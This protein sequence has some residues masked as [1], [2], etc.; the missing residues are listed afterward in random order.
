[1]TSLNTTQPQVSEEIQNSEEV[2]RIV[3]CNIK[4]TRRLS[5]EFKYN[6]KLTKHKSIPMTEGTFNV[7][8]VKS[9]SEFS[10]YIQTLAQDE[11]L[12]Y[13]RPASNDGTILSK[14]LKK[15]RGV[16]QAITRSDDYFDWSPV[17]SIF[18]GDY[19]PVEG[20]D[21]LISN[22]LL[23]KIYEVVP[24]LKT[25]PVML[26]DSASS[27]VYHK[28][29]GDELIGSGGVRI[30]FVVAD[31]RDIPRF[32]KILADRLWLAGH[33]HYVC[34]KAGVLL[35]K[36][37]L[38]TSVWQPSRLDFAAGAYIDE[39][40]VIEQRR[41]TPQLCN[42]DNAPFITSNIPELTEKEEI[43]LAS[44][45]TRKRALI[46]PK[47]VLVREKWI[48]Q[49]EINNPPIILLED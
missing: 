43:S 15:E 39:D 24:E 17:P 9:I 28:Q 16:Q 40:Q 14:K 1:M 25:A 49:L 11:A 5:K 48:R 27:H 37:L 44:I 21:V 3:F 23:N 32:G 19:D 47:Q 41:P 46:E 20:T 36:T 42:V 33:G 13:G 12:C 35:E 4:S 18:F 8:S 2:K 31:G 45:K 10:N 26:G 22:Q 30:Y 29:T 34:S 7:Y 38:D 6:G